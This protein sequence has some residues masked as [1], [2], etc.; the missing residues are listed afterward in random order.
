MGRR[1][2]ILSPRISWKL[3][4]QLSDSEVEDVLN[5]SIITLTLNTE[6]KLLTAQVSQI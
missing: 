1:H 6:F 4:S 2:D 3:T 5:L